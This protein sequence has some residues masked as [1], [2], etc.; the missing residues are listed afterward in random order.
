MDGE[1]Q[2]PYFSMMEDFLR[3]RLVSERNVCRI[4]LKRAGEETDVALSGLSFKGT[5]VSLTFSAARKKLTYLELKTGFIAIPDLMEYID[6]ACFAE[7]DWG[8][9]LFY[10]ERE[11]SASTVS[12]SGGENLLRR[13]W[14]CAMSRRRSGKSRSVG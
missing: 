1:V 4:H 8:P 6:P 11:L 13:I 10:K 9:L 5:P 7:G 2:A 14:R 3:R 12:Y